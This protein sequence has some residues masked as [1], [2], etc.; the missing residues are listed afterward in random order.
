MAASKERELREAQARAEQQRNITESE[1]N[2]TVQTNQGKA[3]YQRALQQAAQIRTMAEAESEK[4]ARTGIAQAIA[5]EEQVQAYGGP[6]FQVTQ[7]V[8]NRFAEAVQQAK[9]DVVPR[10]IV[11][12]GGEQGMANSNLIEGL[13]AMLLSEKFG[14]QVNQNQPHERN[15]EAQRIRAQ[16]QKSMD[17]EREDP[18][19]KPPEKPA[20]KP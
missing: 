12:G 5:T 7:Q 17:L 2:I 1:L 10:V 4:I 8:L 6:Q 20:P 11:G 18:S 13:L 16:I 14:V 9:I 3:E 15:P 19:K